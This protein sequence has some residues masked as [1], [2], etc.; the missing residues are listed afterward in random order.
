MQNFIFYQKEN[1]LA[2]TKTRQGENKLGQTIQAVS[3]V[4]K[5]KQELKSSSSKFVL[6]GIPEDIGVKANYGVGGAHTAWP[7]FL[8]AFFNIQQNRFLDGKS[9]MLLGYFDFSSLHLKAQ[10]KSIEYV[11]DLVS[12]IDKEVT[13][14]VQ[15]IVACGKVPIIIGG[16]HNNAYGNIKGAALGLHSLGKVKAKSI[17]VLNLD[18]HADLRA[19]EG[20]HSG[21]AFSY[22]M[23][24]GFLKKYGML[25]LHES[26]ITAEMDKKISQNKQL[27]AIFFEDIFIRKITGYEEAIEQLL[28]FTK[29]TYTGI[30]VDLDVIEQVLSSALS[31]TGLQTIDA[32][33]FIHLAAKRGK[34]AYLHICEG[35]AQLDNGI[36]SSTTGKL[37]AYLVSDFIKAIK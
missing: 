2:F 34:V 12:E 10:N 31:P 33:R 16:G 18:A 8:N 29:D 4:K 30:E 23:E 6:V 17:N 15:E 22:A 25:G 32:R 26:Y 7:S 21:N 20:R 9:I 28:T 3:N 5:W 19:L 37:I 36:S 24:D 14:I 27:K 13:A 1:F 11:R 35:A